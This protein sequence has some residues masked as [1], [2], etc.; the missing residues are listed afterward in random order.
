MPR[1]LLFTIILVILTL[2][3]CS[4][5]ATTAVDAPTGT[6]Q[7]EATVSAVNQPQQTQGGEPTQQPKMVATPRPTK[8]P[9]Q[10]SRLWRGI[11]V[12]P[13]VRCSP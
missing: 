5:P 13:E 9:A 8:A 4:D 3:A 6:P 7:P 1:A 2:A 10:H 12:A 11:T